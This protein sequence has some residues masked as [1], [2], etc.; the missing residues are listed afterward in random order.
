MLSQLDPRYLSMLKK[1]KNFK[2]KQSECLF[3][4]RFLEKLHKKK[5][6]DRNPHSGQP[7]GH[8][9][10]FRPRRRQGFVGNLQPYS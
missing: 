2:A 9:S 8:F 5:R 6:R 10:T 1:G 7:A 3:G 4:E